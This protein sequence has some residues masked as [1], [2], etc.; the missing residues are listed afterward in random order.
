MIC[1]FYSPALP[2]FYVSINTA[3]CAY[4]SHS[5]EYVEYIYFVNEIGDNGKQIFKTPSC[6]I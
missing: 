4:T 2:Y 1:V 3:S 5:H 6:Y